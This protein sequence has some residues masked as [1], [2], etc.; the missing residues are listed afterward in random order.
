MKKDTFYFYAK[1]SMKIMMLHPPRRLKKR[2]QENPR[3]SAKPS[4]SPTSLRRHYR[5]ED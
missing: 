1:V 4:Y 3:F 5:Q 2:W